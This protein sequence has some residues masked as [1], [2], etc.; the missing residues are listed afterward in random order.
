MVLVF[1]MRQVDGHL[2]DV[3][4]VVSDFA[5]SVLTVIPM[6][7]I[8]ASI[9]ILLK[10]ICYTETSM[11]KLL[12]FAPVHTHNDALAGNKALRLE[13]DFLCYS[14]PHSLYGIVLYLLPADL[15]RDRS[16]VKEHFHV[17]PF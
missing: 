3:A 11:H 16:F 7:A 10:D 17:A 4:A 15:I 5:F 8:R 12:Y 2:C 13:G 6:L 9:P 14:I 1:A